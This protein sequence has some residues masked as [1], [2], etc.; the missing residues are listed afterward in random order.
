MFNFQFRTLVFSALLISTTHA[1]NLD[2]SSVPLYLGGSV[3]PNIMFTLD[4][5]DDTGLPDTLCDVI[6]T[7]GA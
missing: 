6:T 1:A 7:K 2:L 3:E 5:S 4:D